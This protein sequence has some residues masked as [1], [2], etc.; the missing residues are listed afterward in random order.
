M[1]WADSLDPST[2][3]MLS[4]E[5]AGRLVA[6]N[7]DAR[8]V[9]VMDEQPLWEGIATA[10]Y[11]CDLE[12]AVIEGDRVHPLIFACRRTA[13]GWVKTA[14]RQRVL[15]NPTHWRLWSVER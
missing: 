1:L 5:R 15:V 13:S 7:E 12:L 14:N 6:A 4:V 3:L 8:W 11:E 9:G 2:A 10:P